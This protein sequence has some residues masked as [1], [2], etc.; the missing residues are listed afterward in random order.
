[1][2][3]FTND[4][5]DYNTIALKKHKEVKY[6]PTASEMVSN[7]LY[8]AVGKLLGLDMAREWNQLYDKVFTIAEWAKRNTK[9][10]EI[11][12]ILRTIEER[13]GEVP[14]MSGKRINDVYINITLHGDSAPKTTDQQ[15]N[16]ENIKTDKEVSDDGKV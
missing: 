4:P 7:P 1:M 9:S 14:A 11:T 13:I 8:N 10:Q 6:T 2:K 3:L 12:D 16:K 15:T 5:Y